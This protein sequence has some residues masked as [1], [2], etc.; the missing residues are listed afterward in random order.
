M[1]NWSADFHGATNGFMQ[2]REKLRKTG[3]QCAYCPN[4]KNITIDH[5][6]PVSFLSIIGVPERHKD[7][8]NLQLL[9]AACNGRKGNSLDYSNKKTVLLLEKYLEESLK[10]HTPQPKVRKIT[11]RCQCHPV[12]D[13]SPLKPQVV[14]DDDF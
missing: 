5:I 3:G 14:D 13:T 1:T 4:I 8:Q 10:K 9:C 12:A 7:K 6:I 2:M 11:A